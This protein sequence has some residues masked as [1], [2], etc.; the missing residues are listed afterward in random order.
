MVG[1][2]SRTERGYVNRLFFTVLVGDRVSGRLRIVYVVMVKMDTTLILRVSSLI[3]LM[4]LL[5]ILFY[6]DF[7]YEL[8]KIIPIIFIFTYVFLKMTLADM[9]EKRETGG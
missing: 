6:A 7:P 5:V 4:L 2:Y 3:W 9:I 1:G 8:W